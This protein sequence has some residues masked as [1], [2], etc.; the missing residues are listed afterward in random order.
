MSDAPGKTRHLATAT[1]GAAS[2]HR[3][4]FCFFFNCA[5]VPQTVAK[6]VRLGPV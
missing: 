1:N 6:L 2:S 3:F 5:D 4:S